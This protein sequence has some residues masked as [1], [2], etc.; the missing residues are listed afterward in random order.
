MILEV[1]A[2]ESAG[3]SLLCAMSSII[4]EMFKS[5]TGYMKWSLV[6]GLSTLYSNQGLGIVD[7]CGR[8]LSDAISGNKKR[9]TQKRRDSLQR[10]SIAGALC[11]GHRMDLT[12]KV[13]G[14]PKKRCGVLGC[15]VR[16]SHTSRTFALYPQLIPS[17]G[18][19]W[20]K[21]RSAAGTSPS[22]P[23]SSSRSF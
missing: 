2:V 9:Q 16:P 5:R 17:A 23:A 11:I 1:Q 20:P 13:S 10:Q 21:V 19:C 6:E 18:K 4:H 14:F 22:F 8:S 7:S 15:T 12:S 3:I